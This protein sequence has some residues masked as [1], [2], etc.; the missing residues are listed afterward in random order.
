MA[1]NKVASRG[2]VSFKAEQR[3]AGQETGP[4]PAVGLWSAKGLDTQT[5][6]PNLSSSAAQRSRSPDL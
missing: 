3:T 5:K 2:A 1:G 4:A 6:D